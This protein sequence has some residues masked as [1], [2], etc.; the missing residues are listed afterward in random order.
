MS[1]VLLKYMRPPVLIKIS[2]LQILKCLCQAFHAFDVNANGYVEFDEFLVGLAVLSTP[3]VAVSGWADSSL[4]FALRFNDNDRF[5]AVQFDGCRQASSFS[6]FFRDGFLTKEE[7]SLALAGQESVVNSLFESKS[8]SGKVA[9]ATLRPILA[10]SSASL[11]RRSIQVE[12][13]LPCLLY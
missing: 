2:S 12:G 1:Y 10:R 8:Q 4:M 3:T 6:F 9:I 11:N 7:L 13:A 5:G